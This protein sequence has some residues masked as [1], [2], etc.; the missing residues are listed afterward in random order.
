MLPAKYTMGWTETYDLD[1][2][3]EGWHV[4]RNPEGEDVGFFEFVP[5]KKVEQV[6]KAHIKIEIV[7]NS[8]DDAKAMIVLKDSDGNSVGSW[9]LHQHARS[10]IE[11]VVKYLANR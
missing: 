4:L 2:E 11:K 9:E 1:G 7:N 5:G 8:R 10:A 3:K 6:L